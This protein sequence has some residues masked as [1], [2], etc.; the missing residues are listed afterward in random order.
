MTATTARPSAPPLRRTKAGTARPL[1]ESAYAMALVVLDALAITLALGIALA[2]RFSPSQAIVGGPGSSPLHG[3]PYSTVVALLAPVWVAV[4][5]ASRC[6]EPRFLGVGSEEFKRIVNASM[7]FAAL[8]AVLVFATRAAISRQFVGVALPAGVVLLAA[9]RFG[10]R[11]VLHR[12]RRRGRCLHRVVAVGSADE[13]AHLVRAVRREPH[14]GFQVVGICLAD[15]EQDA[16]V[17]VEGLPTLGPA[18]ALAGRLADVGADTVAVAGTAAMS[19]RELRQLSWELEGTGVDLVVAPAI[20]DVTGPR[21]HIRP[22]AGLPLLHVEEP[23]FGGFRRLIKTALDRSLALALLLFLIVPLI[24]IA[25]LV[26]LDSSGPI[27]Y[28]QE[29]V[30]RDGR[31]FHIWKFRSMRVGAESELSML[32]ELNEQDGPLFKIRNDPRVTRVGARLRRNSLDELPQLFNVLFGS[33]SL[34]GPRPPLAS[35]VEQYA[36]HVRRRLLVKPGMTGL[37][38]VSGRNDLEWEEAVRLDLYYVEN[39]SVLLDIMILWRTFFAVLR[40]RG[41]Y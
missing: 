15:Y 8:V 31:P 36:D 20:T 1:W 25:V 16:G 11:E 13:V 3:V 6:Y 37:W 2:L 14:A 9:G 7:R 30:G 27:F 28:R 10:M 33:M 39:W 22:V 19:S 26:R 18:R 24:A 4:L 5:A 40:G 23:T 41:A 21:I 32:A 38:Q 29:R 17:D 12:I 34:V 35:E